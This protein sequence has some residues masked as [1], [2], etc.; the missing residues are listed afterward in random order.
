MRPLIVRLPH[1]LAASLLALAAGSAAA[2][3]ASPPPPPPSGPVAMPYPTP[4]PPP[5]PECPYSLC[6]KAGATQGTGGAIPHKHIGN[7]KYSDFAK[8]GA[9]E[10]ATAE[11]TETPDGPT[12]QVELVGLWWGKLKDAGTVYSADPMEGGQIAQRTYQ[13][14]RP[15]YGNLIGDA[16]VMVPEP[17]A[18]GTATFKTLAGACATGKHLD[19]VKIVLRSHGFTLHDAT[20]VSVEP[21]EPVDG[22]AMEQVTLSYA[23]IEG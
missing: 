16:P 19:K 22:Q 5:V 1:I 13:P 15:T 7:V 18:K 12:Q 8:S 20:V 11:F 2:D 3:P 21:V 6:P 10:T 14:G 23:S 17:V 4:D 9:A